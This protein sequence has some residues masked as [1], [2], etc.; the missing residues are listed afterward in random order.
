MAFMRD[1]IERVRSA[2]NIVDLVDSVTT[3]RKRGRAVKAICPFH[4]E[5]T[6]SMSIDVARGLYHCFGCGAGGDVFKFVQETQALDFSEA[7]EH[8]AARSGITL[9]IDKEAARQR[10]ERQA[11]IE[12]IEKAVEFFHDRLK[13][14]PDAASARK[15]L[16][17]RGYDGEVVDR[18]QIGYSPAETWDALVR[19]LSGKGVNEK[20]MLDAGLAAR[21]QR[22][23]LRD[24]FRGRVM[25]PIND[26]SGSPVGFGARLL[27]GEGPKYLNSPETRIYR[28]A[29]LL[30]GLDLAKAAITRSGY[31]LV[32][33]GYTDVIGL[34]LADLPVAVA[35]C[36]TALGEEHFD[37]LRRFSER[38]VLA[39]DADEAGVGAA[40]RGD[41]LSTP[42]D[43]DLDVRVAVMPSGADPA[44]MVQS[45]RLDE[46]RQAVEASRPLLEFRID[47][48]LEHHNIGEAEGRARAVRSAAMLIARQSDEIVRSEYARRVARATGVDLGAVLKAVQEA[49]RSG[50]HPGRRSESPGPPSAPPRSTLSGSEQAERELLRLMLAN[51]SRLPLDALDLDLF[52]LAEHRAYFEAVYPLLSSTP[53][54][55]VIDLGALP[56]GWGDALRVIVLDERPLDH[57]PKALVQRLERWRTERSIVEV[58]KQIDAETAGSDT[59][60]NLL[61]QL[62]ALE[63][64]KRE[65]DSE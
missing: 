50:G 64:R 35:T 28:K 34:H 51:D 65:L 61:R 8:L 6:A 46:L 38:I 14:A 52:S 11:L 41:E 49:L 48:E 25:F 42:A 55:T 31:S 5:K 4:Q 56:E 13:N 33:E 54:G 19:Y 47:R 23:G 59:H 58:R 9:R 37:L 12:A 21:N 60:S 40:L 15:Y 27:D 43:L 1:D 7:V 36:G 24:W 29:Q 32:V 18:F 39:F 16:R 57:D 30:Y 17:G 44:D 20:T 53:P 45:G 63:R 10:G 22:G 2:T 62:I 26:I 3:V